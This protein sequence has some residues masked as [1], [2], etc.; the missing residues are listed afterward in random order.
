[1][2]RQAPQMSP[3]QLNVGPGSAAPAASRTGLP[4]GVSTKEA[5]GLSR[6]SFSACTGLLLLHDVT[7]LDKAC[8]PG[9][10]SPMSWRLQTSSNTSL[11]CRAARSSSAWGCCISGLTQQVLLK[12]MLPCSAQHS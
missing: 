9:S 7:M 5:E 1:M 11:Q 2:G 6:C 10:C 12:C 3:A 8:Q 4:R